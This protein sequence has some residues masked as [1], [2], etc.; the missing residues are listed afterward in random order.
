MHSAV[1]SSHGKQ[2]LTGSETTQACDE[3][4]FIHFSQLCRTYCLGHVCVTCV[5]ATCIPTQKHADTESG[6]FR[7][8]QRML[9]E[10]TQENLGLSAGSYM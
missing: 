4:I 9:F 10:Y 8:H 1:R 6:V 7:R 2:T 3:D 5:A